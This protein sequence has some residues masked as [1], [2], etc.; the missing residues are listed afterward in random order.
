MRPMPGSSVAADKCY[1]P[2]PSCKPEACWPPMP[3]YVGEWPDRQPDDT[4]ERPLHQWGGLVLGINAYDGQPCVEAATSEGLLRPLPLVGTASY[5][6][7]QCMLH[8]GGRLGLGLAHLNRIFGG[9]MT[10]ATAC[11]GSEL[12]KPA[13]K[14]LDESLKDALGMGLAPVHLW[15]CE[16]DPHKATWIQE[17]MEVN[18]VYDDVGELD[19]MR[20]TV[21]CQPRRMPEPA[22]YLQ[23]EDMFFAGFSCKSVS[24]SNGERQ[25][26]EDCIRQMIG[27]T[28]LTFAGIRR[29]SRE[30]RPF[31]LFLENVAGL[32]GQNLRMVV[33][34]LEG[35]GYIV[36]VLTER[37]EQHGFQVRRLRVWLCCMLDP[38]CMLDQCGRD[39]RDAMQ[40]KA[41][42]LAHDLRRAEPE[43][44]VADFLFE[45]GSDDFE[46]WKK[47]QSREKKRAQ[48]AISSGHDIKWPQKHKKAW[49]A[50]KKKSTQ[51]ID[52]LTHLTESVG[53]AGRKTPKLRKEWKSSQ[54]VLQRAH[55]ARIAMT[56]GK[57]TGLTAREKDVVK[58]DMCTHWRAYNRSSSIFVLD[59]SQSL[60]RI[61]RGEGIVPSLM[62]GGKLVAVPGFGPIADD[63]AKYGLPRRILGAEMLQMQGLHTKLLPHP[64]ESRKFKDYE[65]KDLAGNAFSGPQMHLAV[66][67]A[68]SVFASRMPLDFED[69]RRRRDQVPSAPCYIIIIYSLEICVR[70]F[71][72]YI[73]FTI[74]IV[75]ACRFD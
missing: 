24:M 20:P 74:I 12:T 39:K 5:M 65:L 75:F 34:L 62:P 46:F 7:R 40:L 59:V 43:A 73:S 1:G 15:S 66:V 60:G 41:T 2:K 69:W 31:F 49:D 8:S 16:N 4:P 36:I 56:L 37:L 61:P 13:L 19:K 10:Y 18:T 28:G 64:K 70:Q 52:H 27:T 25:D 42:Q 57:L 17:V 38:A 23:P 9:S 67:V 63:W 21:W 47:K 6:V 32:R 29:H 11:S 35:L 51:G 33:Q 54:R 44:A 71:W 58:Y 72:C 68:I 26:F 50:L 45:V 48:D 3:D 55:D 14:V 22:L 53:Q 30:V